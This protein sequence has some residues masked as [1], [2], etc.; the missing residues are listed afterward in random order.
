M[1][2]THVISS[3]SR[4][5]PAIVIALALSMSA[6]AAAG[7]DAPTDPPTITEVAS[8]EPATASVPAA[9]S[10]HYDALPADSEFQRFIVKYRADSAPGRTSD[11][12]RERLESM[13]A[14]S[15]VQIEWLRRLGVDADVFKT[16]RRLDREA[17][18]QLMDRFSADPDVEYIEVDSILT[19]R[20]GVDVPPVQ[21]LR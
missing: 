9:G 6:C 15:G 7:G 11:D 5:A 18:A 16:D 12:A 20:K 14:Q 4:F 21:P 3:R 19:I 1:H 17:A 10:T 8:P 13:Q 2:V